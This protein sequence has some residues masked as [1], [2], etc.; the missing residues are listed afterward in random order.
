MYSTRCAQI[1]R[2]LWHPA[3]IFGAL[4][5]AVFWISLNYQLSIDRERATEAAI[6]NGDRLTR[7][8]S[9]HI[10]Q[11]VGT[12][13]RTLLL[14]R[15][16]YEESPRQFDLNQWAER[17]SL[18]NGATTEIGMLDANLYLRARTGY[19]GP[20]IYLG[21]RDHVQASVNAA[22]DELFITKPIVLRT[23]GKRSIQL[24]RKLR[25]PD[26]S[27]AGTVAIQI[28]P[29][30]IES[31]Y[32]TLGLAPNDSVIL[33]G[34]DGVIRASSGLSTEASTEEGMPPNIAHALAGAPVGF[35]WGSGNVDNIS[36]LVF[37]RVIEG[38][39][40]LISHGKTFPSLLADY[41]RQRLIYVVVGSALTLLVLLAV[42]F[43]IQRQLSLE[44]ANVRFDSAIE[45]MSQG[46][47]MFDSDSRLL[48]SNR[49]YGEMYELPPELLRIGTP[50]EEIIAFRAKQGDLR[51]DP[52][53]V[54]A[55]T[56][57]GGSFQLSGRSSRVNELA[58]GR[59]VC[60]SRIPMAGG[61]WVAT[62]D[63]ITEQK[64][65][66]QERAAMERRLVQSQKLEAVGQLT[67]GIAHDF[68]NLLLVIIGNLDL[69]KDATPAGSSELDLIESS[70]T[71]ALTGS[72]LSSGLLAFSRQHA[73][74]PETID[75]RAVI[76]DQV[77]LLRRAMGGKVT[78]QEIAAD[79]SCTVMVDVAQLRCALTNLVV[80]ARDAMPDGGEIT[81]RTYNAALTEQDLVNQDK[82]KPG[83]Y[84]VMEVA[85]SGAGI[86]P[87]NLNRIFEPFFT[88]K[89]VGKGT[90]LGLS[91]VYGFVTEMKGTIKVVSE[92]GKGTSFT[93]CF[94]AAALLQDVAAPGLVPSESP[95]P[96][97]KRE[98][99]LVV[100]DDPMVRK[101]V[102][103]QINSLGYSVVEASSP[104]EALNV[105]ARDEA[106]DLVFS[107]IVMPGSIDGIELARLVRE[108]R[109]DLKVLLT[110]GY[111]NLKTARSAEDSFAQWDILK[112]PYRRPDLKQALE[113]ALC[114]NEAKA[115][116]H[117]AVGG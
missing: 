14:L 33:R 113:N 13:D 48:V 79:D 36:R 112:K 102:V 45:N 111:P 20:P 46:L 27:F 8:I 7:L 1:F 101:S 100:D 83:D 71:A 9:D 91:M 78:L 64:R 77:R 70:L 23:N 21:D 53:A 82:A 5:I 92:V 55:L 90:G 54:E 25:N 3:P 40:L 58:D 72:E 117:V 47:C 66:E 116:P 28:D 37:Y 2:A 109:P 17:A 10:A 95:A 56:K 84:V 65:T 49:R 50:F 96:L 86:S 34:L 87:E 19:S 59:S 61:G 107:D 6:Q 69:L 73:F 89:D 98:I 103:A 12:I 81:I 43:S 93:L 57:P 108:R 110:S 99:V 60:V 85:D 30:Q 94:P 32:E 76:S 97:G 106:L 39:P 80:N 115:D 31:F 35:F 4:V 104:A 51:G 75:I 42:A 114:V 16:A 18:I 15:H 29:K 74:K 105:I 68:N 38:F 22:G 67:G 41:E 63:D 26:G 88:T 52:V 11:L 44:R 24:S 62:H